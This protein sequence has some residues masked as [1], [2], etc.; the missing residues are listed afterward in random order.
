[1]R[2]LLLVFFSM[3]MLIAPVLTQTV[4]FTEDFESG[5][6]S[7]AWELYRTGEEPLQA[8]PMGSAPAALAGGG[9]F[10]GYLQDADASYYGAA[11]ALAG[12]VS[13][14]NYTIEADV[15]CYVYNPNGSAYTGVVVYGDSSKSIYYKLVVDFDGSDRFRLYNNRS[16]SLGNYAFHVT[17]PA[18][19]YY[20]S[21]DWH[22]MKLDVNSINDSTTQF[23]CYF[24]GG[25]IGT[26]FYNDTSGYQ[27]GSGKFGLFSF[28]ADTNGLEGYFDNIVV[29]DNGASAIEDNVQL[30]PEKLTLGQNYPNPFNPSTTIEF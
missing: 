9:N 8:V 10:V 11:I 26:G 1:M 6:P 19:G 12:D 29:T 21:D 3:V 25:V 4:I 2:V 23:L 20:S 5:S 22:H 16:D 28:Q 24:D 30:L 7:T 15:Y 27:S 18:T 14:Q 17:I 13:R